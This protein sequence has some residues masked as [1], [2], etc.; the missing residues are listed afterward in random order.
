[1]ARYQTVLDLAISFKDWAAHQLL[2]QTAVEA[3][4]ALLEELLIAIGRAH[5]DDAVS[6]YVDLLQRA[7]EDVVLLPLLTPDTVGEVI[8][9]NACVGVRQEYVQRT[10]QI[11][12]KLPTDREENYGGSRGKELKAVLLNSRGKMLEKICTR[13]RETKDEEEADQI[14]EYLLDL[15]RTWG[16]RFRFNDLIE[17]AVKKATDQSFPIPRLMRYLTTQCLP[18][19]LQR[20]FALALTRNTEPRQFATIL[21]VGELLA[22]RSAEA[23]AY[24]EVVATD[25]DALDRSMDVLRACF[26]TEHA[27]RRRVERASVGDVYRWPS[28]SG[29]LRVVYTAN[30]IELTLSQSWRQLDKPNDENSFHE[31]FEFVAKHVERWQ[32]M[33]PRRVKLT[34]VATEH[35]AVKFDRAKDFPV[36]R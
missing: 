16:P 22:T 17:T 31:W 14:L 21:Q 13:W 27:A 24:A 34:V 28:L 26:T 33:F 11:L 1:M 12:T 19:T 3:R 5:D 30:A 8:A 15:S 7:L 35:T 20:H 36:S 6:K 9:Y 10:T 32:R 23:Q 2:E 4:P 25:I 29:E 18:D